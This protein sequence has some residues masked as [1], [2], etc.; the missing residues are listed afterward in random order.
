MKNDKSFHAFKC[1]LMVFL[2]VLFISTFGQNAQFTGENNFKR[3]AVSDKIAPNSPICIHKDTEGFMWFGSQNGLFRFDAYDL[4]YWRHAP[5][6]STT[7]GNNNVLCLGRDETGNLLVGTKMGL[8]K[9]IPESNTFV[10]FVDSSGARFNDKVHCLYNSPNGRVLAGTETG[11]YR[12]NSLENRLEKLGFQGALHN[13]FPVLSMTESPDGTGLWMGTFGQGLVRY[14]WNTRKA[15]PI[16]DG[17][18][19]FEQ[20]RNISFF[21]PR[22]LL[23]CKNMGLYNLDVASEN[24][25]ALLEGDCYD[26]ERDINGF[27]WASMGHELYKLDAGLKVDNVFK[28]GEGQE[29]ER[30]PGIITDIFSD[31]SGMVWLSNGVSGIEIMEGQQGRLDKEFVATGNVSDHKGYVKDFYRDGAGNVWVATFGKG[32]WEYDKNLKQVNRLKKNNPVLTGSHV[33]CLYPVG[34]NKLWAG[35]LEGAMEIDVKSLNITKNITTSNGLWHN[36]II[37]LVTDAGNKVWIATQEGLNK[38]DPDKGAIQRYSEADGLVDYK[39]TRLFMDSFHNIWIGTERGFCI[40]SLQEDRFVN[41]DQSDVQKYGLNGLKVFCFAQGYEGNIWIG[42][43][44]GLFR[45][46]YR[47]KSLKRYL[48]EDGLAENVVNNV[49]FDNKKRM[50]LQHP[51]VLAV[52]MSDTLQE[53][54][55]RMYKGLKINIHSMMDP[56]GQ[57]FVGGL[58]SGFYV[59]QTDSMD[60]ESLVPPVHIVE[61]N[62]FEKSIPVPEN[63]E[64]TL[65]YSRNSLRITF[66]ALNYHSPADNRFAYKMEG[67]DN[68]WR[69]TGAHNREVTYSYLQPGTYTFRVRG[70]NNYNVWNNVGDKLH[71]SIMPPWW[72]TKVFYAAFVVLFMGLLLFIQTIRQNRINLLNK[73]K[74]SREQARMEHEAN[75]LKFKYFTDVSHEFR[76]PLTLISVPI[77]SVLSNSMLTDQDTKNLQLAKKNINRLKNLINQL[78]DYRKIT[79]DKIK[80]NLRP[81]EI[82]GYIQSIMDIFVPYVKN[83]QIG[84]AFNTNIKAFTCL[85]DVDILDKILYNLVSN[86]IKNTEEQGKVTVEIKVVDDGDSQEQEK[87]VGAT[88]EISISNTG[89]G[90]APEH[91][92][93]V[94]NRFYQVPGT[95]MQGGTGIGLALVK[96]FVE[97]LGGRIKLESIPKKTTTFYLSFPAERIDGNKIEESPLKDQ[98][99]REEYFNGI[100]D[101]VDV[102]DNRVLEE[103]TG[104]NGKTLLVVEDNPDLRKVINNL[105]SDEFNVIETENGKEGLEKALEHVPDLIISDVMMPEMDGIEFC[106]HCKKNELI[107]HVPVLLLTAKATGEDE[108]KGYH[109]G[110]DAYITKP[111]SIKLLK[112]IIKN[113][114]DNRERLKQVYAENHFIDVV[115]VYTNLTEKSF[116]SKLKQVFKE[117]MAD[118][119]F[120]ATVLASKLNIHPSQ[121]SRKFTGQFGTSPSNY[122][123]SYRMNAALK[124]LHNS[125]MNIAEIAY[126]VGIKHV[127]NFTKLFQK[128]FGLSPTEYRKKNKV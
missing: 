86:A 109:T 31:E 71:I 67:L 84:Y 34:K 94:F 9:Y 121:L 1:I 127:A 55:F 60:M 95:D 96:E 13:G 78:L 3:L 41:M 80:V 24:A 128:Q 98:V 116:I 101:D 38:Y 16:E 115:K 51:G 79:K 114:L 18:D 119:N 48:V 102:D 26:V 64:I 43:E 104:Y 76:T 42:T 4:R 108:I 54:A 46:N 118:E 20:I 125:N 47:D 73:L 58:N 57:L 8:D 35:T 29:H 59:V 82:M 89:K 45:Y 113:I 49:H 15:L 111:F 36:A 33:T 70:S 83:K 6:D 5:N 61:I 106:G 28:H 85:F 91:V 12:V 107:S 65:P 93:N 90:I 87:N 120:N 11:L 92:P 112:S 30:S 72:R 88:L 75:E 74:L 53:S 105:L 14:D 117:N 40:F 19:K 62:N 124:M 103:S 63:R 122:I 10:H 23:L 110:A 99:T 21:S 39:P 25:T 27:A 50:W 52:L 32:L 100:I 56:R 68:Q 77:E 44:S 66:T 17:A 7:L 97:L 123:R 126:N 22:T 69:H 2:N 81:V 37:D